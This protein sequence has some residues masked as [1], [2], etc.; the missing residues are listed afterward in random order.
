MQVRNIQVWLLLGC[1]VVET[2]NR[3]AMGPLV[4]FMCEEM[5]CDAS[6]KG[7]LL[8]AFSLGYVTTQVAGGAL[9]DKVGPKALISFA[10]FGAGLATIATP[11]GSD[12]TGL[13]TITVIMGAFQGPL[14]PTSIAF[15]S[16][17]TPPS[18]RA[19]ASTMVDSGITVGS[20]IALPVSGLLGASIGWRNTY[21]CYG[22]A[23]LL[24]AGLWHSLAEADPHECSYI[25]EEELAYL[26]SAIHIAPANTIRSDILSDAS[27]S[28]SA[29]IGSISQ[30]QQSP[31]A[32]LRELVSHAS[33]WS[34]FVAHMAFNYGVYFQNSWTPI[35]YADELGLRPEAA[36]MHFVA[37]H[38]ANLLV[39]VLLA[40]PLMRY[41]EV[42]LGWSLLTC[43]RWFTVTGFVFASACF[44]LISSAKESTVF[45][46]FGIGNSFSSSGGS[47][48]NSGN[49]SS[50]Q[51]GPH[52]TTLLFTLAMGACGLH[53][54]GFKANYM[55]VS[56]YSR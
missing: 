46:S 49:S 42:R 6:N 34:I 24:Y 44:I 28:E 25:S 17:W 15:L 31:R 36:G 9:A 23:T 30:N 27:E 41:F 37:P 26:D 3:M 52:A 39:K 1:R 16:K 48:S 35:Y 53:P 38:I 54:S 40:P 11:L 2:I 14:F 32:S 43:R 7:S 20:L 45:G 10:M 50:S 19:F 4:V 13:W 33:L 55:D 29:A 18:E 8:S 21:Y 47:S 5:T 12:V 51:V 56:L 22:V